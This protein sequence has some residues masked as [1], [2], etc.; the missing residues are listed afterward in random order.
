MNGSATERR[1]LVINTAFLGDVVL[2]TPLFALLAENG[3]TV[4][5]LVLPRAA[6]LLEGHPR[7]NRVIAYDKRR[8]PGPGELL[9]LGRGLR[10]RYNAVMVPHRS[11]RSALLAR[12]TRTPVRIGYK[13]PEGPVPLLFKNRNLRPCFTA[14]RFLYTHRVEYRLGLQE[15]RRICDL[16]GA[17]GIEPVG[18][19]V[20]GLAV[21]G[22]DRRVVEGRLEGLDRP[23]A[24][25]FP[26]SVWESKRYPA[27]SYAAV[28]RYLAAEARLG[29]VVCGSAE[30][31]DVCGK[32]SAD[33]PGAVVLTDLTLGGLK[34]LAEMA[35]LVVSNDSAPLHVAAALG[36]P[37]V[38]V[39]GPTTPAFGFRPPRGL[40]HR[41]V[42]HGRLECQPCRLSPPKACPLG[43]HRCMSELDPE[44]VVAACRELLEGVR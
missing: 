4:D 32:V 17:L 23:F 35:A 39:Y 25:L 16:A 19:P 44:R 38:V 29:V 22:D 40:P 42:Y 36:T 1:A 5:A 8:K 27:A 41:L 26:G 3:W 13:P 12:L 30:E 18:E 15:G 37:A 11:A 10:G 34:A 14:L 6:E 28:G 2:T 21:A 9:S 24:V 7:L 33:I 43:H 31:A 20:G